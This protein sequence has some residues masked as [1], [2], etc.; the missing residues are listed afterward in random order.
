MDLSPTQRLERA[1][2]SLIRD[3][4]YMWLAGIIVMGGNKII[5]DPDLTARTDGYNTEYGSE[6]IAG[7]T[8]AELMGLVLHEK[9]HCAFKHMSTWKHLYDKDADIAN[10]ACDYVINLPINDRANRDGFVRLPKGGCVDEKYRGMDAGEVFRGLEQD[11]KSGKKGGGKDKGFDQHDWESAK[12][13]TDG[14]SEELSKTIDQALRQGN[15]MASKAGANVDRDI[16]DMLEP[17]VDW[18]TALREFVTNCKRGD[19]YSSYRRVDRRMMSQDIMTPTSY[20]D[21]VYRIVLGVD[22]SGS[23]GNKELAAFLAEV[24]GV[25]ETTKPEL[26]DLLYWGHNVAA[27]EIYDSVSIDTLHQ[28]T[29]PVGGGGTA[30]SCVT[31]YLR[32]QRIVPDCIVML[33]DGDVFGDWGGTW[34]APTL[35]CISNK[36]NTAPAGVTVHI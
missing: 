24:Q 10:Q 3:T 8:D 7:L 2:V 6:F 33:T 35:W 1:H 29:R 17:K 11:K 28:S 32:E 20:T 26:V 34:P 30:P 31:Q 23:I 21:H 4:E 13:M 25:C 22:S 15:I 36:Y 18:R 9:M 16:L 14:E 27:H 19:D 5:D 12:Q